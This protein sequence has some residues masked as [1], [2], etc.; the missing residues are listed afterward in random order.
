LG[1]VNYLG[2]KF[3]QEKEDEYATADIFA[4]PT[5]YHNEC[6]PLVLLEAMQHKLPIVTTF[7]G[8]IPDIV[9][10][11]V[12]GFLV[13]QKD[14]EKFANRLELLIRNSKLRHSMGIAGRKK[15]E[16]EYV[17]DIFVLKLLNIL[18]QIIEK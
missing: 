14:V 9:E 4:F 7:E 5:F 16:K 17:L 10:D 8:G 15:Y 6:F 3:D 11:E 13:I 1:Y 18:R 2:T 12:T